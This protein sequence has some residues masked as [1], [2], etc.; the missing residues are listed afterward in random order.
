MAG[1]S[2]NEAN[3]I[4]AHID[5]LDTDVATSCHQAYNGIR[6]GA[7]QAEGANAL[8]SEMRHR[9]RGRGDAIDFR[10]TLSAALLSWREYP[11]FRLAARENRI[12]GVFVVTAAARR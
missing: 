7:C 3:N 5:R 4:I 11:I 1:A 9:R 2:Q 8:A 10:A 12:V 6:G